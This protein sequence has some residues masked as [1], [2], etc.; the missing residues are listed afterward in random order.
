MNRAF[1][2]TVTTTTPILELLHGLGLRWTT[3]RAIIHE[4]RKLGT[5][6][7][8]SKEW[9]TYQNYSKSA[10]TT[11]LG[12]HKEPRTTSKELQASLVLSMGDF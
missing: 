8:P 5:S 12:G 6:F 11:H 4:W 10:L 9:P 2:S 7:E 1:Y 3:V